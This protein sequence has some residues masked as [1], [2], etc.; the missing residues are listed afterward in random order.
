MHLLFPGA[1]YTLPR[2]PPR[3]PVRSRTLRLAPV[4][5]PAGPSRLF[6]TAPPTNPK[7][8]GKSPASGDILP[9]QRPLGTPIKPTSSP[10]S[11]QQ[12]KDEMLDDDRAKAKRKA[13]TARGG[14]LWI[15]PNVLIREDKA[16]YFPDITGKSLMGQN[17]HT[18]DVFKGKATLVTI[19]STRLSEE[20]VQSFV[21]PVLEDLEG[22]PDFQFLTINHQPNALKSLL[23]SFFTSSLK[24]IVPEHQWPTYLISA[25]SWSPIDVIEPLGLGN[26]LLGYVF[27]VDHNAKV[28]WAACGLATEDEVKSFRRAAAVLVGRMKGGVGAGAGTESKAG[29]KAVEGVVDPALSGSH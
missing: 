16:N 18:T 7:P 19:I 24:R 20:H 6:A 11:W 1:A 2:M 21:Q 22:H 28:R 25:G 15:A 13:L 10:K 12:K 4:T 27:L 14:K 3:L 9:L 5:P 8:K 29:E 23:V 17:V 26:S